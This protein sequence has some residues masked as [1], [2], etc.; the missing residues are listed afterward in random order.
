MNCRDFERRIY[1]YEENTPSERKLLDQ[2]LDHC[3]ACKQ[4]A[5]EVFQWQA[6]IKKEAALKPEPGSPHQLTQ[7]IM[8]GVMKE[9]SGS[10]ID[11][12]AD[13]LD[14]FFVRFA[15]GTL[16]ILL[17]SFFIYE[18]QVT[19]YS[20]SVHKEPTKKAN[21]GPVL[22]MASYMRTYVKRIENEKAKAHTSRYSYY[23][24]KQA[25][26]NNL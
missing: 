5:Q 1:S 8:N 18:Q 14:S 23:K 9:K 19:V 22:N 7:R 10:I 17:I 20:S 21:H 2:H 12:L 11:V 6:V 25:E 24:S 13:Y 4:L 26:K 15:V 3:E 16:A